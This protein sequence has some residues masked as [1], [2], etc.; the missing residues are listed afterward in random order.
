[1]I[2][3]GHMTG[4]PWDFA[5]IGCGVMGAATLW[6]LAKRGAKA[7]GLD[8]FSPPHDQGSSHGRTRLLRVAYAEGEDYTPLAREA[9]GLWR[10]LEAETGAPI[11]DQSG[12]IYGGAPDNAELAAIA[13]AAAR[14]DVDLRVIGADFRAKIAPEFALPPA[15][16]LLLDAEGGFLR[17]ELAV[18]SLLKAAQM[19]GAALK[20]D[21]KVALV[22]REND[23]W[24]IETTQETLFAGAIVLACGP[25]I[26]EIAPDMTRFLRLQ[27]RVSHW[28]VAPDGAFD[29]ENGFLPFCFSLDGHWLYGFPALGDG[30]IKL[31]DHHFGADFAA[32][33]ALDR[34]VSAAD[35]VTT[36]AFAA[37]FLPRLGPKI[38]SSVCVYT[39][40]PDEHFV[41]G[42]LPE[43]QNAVILTG[44]S[45]HG[46]KFAPAIGEIAAKTAMLGTEEAIAPIWRLSRLFG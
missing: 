41:I 20:T 5:V 23:H 4:R 6:A 25:Y 42:M 28:H 40:S 35:S 2:L 30:Q 34:R 16:S 11:F 10:A 12:V 3:S 1:M 13:R 38:A 26:A 37:H 24:R 14:F 33:P 19:R 32:M 44:F 27:R 8:Q 21:D 36:D 39:T 22:A 45:G 43:R 17:A 9:I 18:K 15:F 7:V 29:R 46:F 31:G